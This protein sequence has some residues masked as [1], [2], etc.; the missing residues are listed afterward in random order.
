MR[1]KSKQR[2]GAIAVLVAVSLIAIVG[3]VAIA[4]D[5]GLLLDNHRRVQSAADASALAAA[6]DLFSNYAANNGLD[7][8]GTAHASALSTAAANDY[9]NDGATSAV[10]VNIPPQSGNFVG[11]AGY[12]EV[13]IQY[14]QTRGF[15]SIFGS[16]DLPVTARAVARGVPGNIGILVL[17]PKISD[18]AELDGPNMTVQNQGQIFVNSSSSTGTWLNK[19]ANITL[20]GMNL[21]GGLDNLGGTATY[22]GSGLQLKADTEVDPLMNIPEPTDPNITVPSGG[23]Q[24]GFSGSTLYG[25]NPTV[26]IAGMTNFGSVTITSDTTL[27]PGIYTGIT[28]GSSSGPG[29]SY[30]SNPAVSSSGPTVTLAPGLYYLENPSGG[31]PGP[32]SGGLNLLSGTLNGTGV[33]FVVATGKDNFFNNNT[34]GVVNIT[35]PTPTSGGTWPSGTSSATYNGISVWI[36]RGD[37]SEY[38]V[39]GGYNMNMP[40]TWYAQGGEFD[41]RPSGSATYQIGNYI[42]DQAEWCQGYNG[43]FG[44]SSGTFILNPNTAAPNLRPTLVE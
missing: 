26:S 36:P 23:G 20:G 33:M 40:G 4:L 29:T 39:I 24:V 37:F 22:T 38:H 30:P 6:D 42:C 34:N 21:V 15:S 9:S 1:C 2:R 25:I 3:V 11:K 19:G 44:M 31:G 27:Q 14:N 12:A 13:I 41:I 18:S 8:S 35:P 7:P 43:S 32:G 16:G 5:G 10:T 17:D 28:I